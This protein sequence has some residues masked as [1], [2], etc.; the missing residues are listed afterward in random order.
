MRGNGLAVM[1]RLRPTAWGPDTGLFRILVAST[2]KSTGF[3]LVRKGCGGVR[4]IQA[5]GLQF[6]GMFR[7]F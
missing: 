1:L 3:R 7:V 5:C 6:F 2:S 4:L